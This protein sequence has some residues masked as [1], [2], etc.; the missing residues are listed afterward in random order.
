MTPNTKEEG[1][2]EVL[3]RLEQIT[4]IGLHV[5]MQIPVLFFV[6]SLSEVVDSS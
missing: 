1:G 4:A 5:H 3:L 6:Q 2:F